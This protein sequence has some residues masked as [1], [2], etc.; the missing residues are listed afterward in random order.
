METSIDLA[1]FAFGSSGSR[2]AGE[3]FMQHIIE[4]HQRQTELNKMAQEME[5]RRLELE[6]ADKDDQKTLASQ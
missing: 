1:D 2:K 6:N 3:A 4:F 5:R